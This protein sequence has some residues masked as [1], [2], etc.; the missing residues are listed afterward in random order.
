MFLN[1]CNVFVKCRPI[2]TSTMLILSFCWWWWWWWIGDWSD[3]LRLAVAWMVSGTFAPRNFSFRD[4]KCLAVIIGDIEISRVRTIPNKAPNTQYPIILAYLNAN[5]QC[6][7]Q[8]RC[9]TKHWIECK[10]KTVQVNI[11]YI[12]ES[13]AVT[14]LT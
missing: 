10:S 13:R 2:C 4:L 5:S 3:Y 12:L 9:L 11:L 8:Y 14:N 6:Q 1:V 7:Y